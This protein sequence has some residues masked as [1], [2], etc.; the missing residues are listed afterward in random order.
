MKTAD[1]ELMRAINRFHVMDAIRQQGPISRVE[2]SARTELSPATVSAITAALLDDS[3]I[4]ATPMP[5]NGETTRGR[6]R[7][8]L[9]LN[10]EAA[11]VVGVKLTSRSISVAV[12][13]FVSRPLATLDMPVRTE[14]QTLDVIADIVEDGIRHCV[15]DA[16]LTMQAI[17]GICVGVPGVVEAAAG[18]CK[19][20]PIFGDEPTP[21]GKAL[22]ARLAIPV[23]LESDASLV[24]LAELWFGH[25]RGHSH[26]MVVS[27][28]ATIGIGIMHQEVLHRGAHGM[29][30]DCAWLDGLPSDAL[31]AAIA[32]LAS[33]L[34]PPLIILSGQGLEAGE[35]LTT[36]L[37]ASFEKHLSPALHGLIDIVFHRWPDEAWARG[38][39]ALV[40]RDLYGS[41]WNTTGP[42]R[43]PR[44]E[45]KP[46]AK[47]ITKHS[48]EEAA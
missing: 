7:V 33:L 4:L 5:A 13:D 19:R 26:F 29:S 20:G 32:Q 35:R 11:H 6:P 8:M 18:V 21:L 9:E 46:I 27:I 40:L 36:P 25:G 48:R 39:A 3:L 42:S 10:P 17:H 43:A 14:R 47:S 12:T 45:P 31:G 37:L 23:K 41:P 2:I 22:E 30:P 15:A 34:A 16:S 1:P 28:E 38:A 24:T 44:Q